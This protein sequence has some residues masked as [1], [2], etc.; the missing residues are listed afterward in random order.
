MALGLVLGAIV[1]WYGSTAV[2]SFLFPF[3]FSLYSSLSASSGWTRDA[4]QAGR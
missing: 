2:K 1:A 3:P 4:R